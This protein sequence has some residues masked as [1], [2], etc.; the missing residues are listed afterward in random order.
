M[1]LEKK[2]DTGIIQVTI[3]L[4]FLIAGYYCTQVIQTHVMS[5]KI[6]KQALSDYGRSRYSN[7]YVKFGKVGMFSILKPYALYRQAMCANALS[8]ERSRIKSYNALL[9]RYPVHPL[10]LEAKYEV[11]QFLSNSNPKLA[12][13]YFK[14]IISSAG[15]NDYKVPARYF[16][17]KI[18]AKSCPYAK[19]SFNKAKISSIEEGF[20]NY[21]E[22]YPDGRLASAV[23]DSWI[24]YNPNN[25]SSHD[26]TL[27]A[28]GYYHSQQYDL[29]LK[30]LSKAEN[31][32]SWA[33]S[34]LNYMALN[35]YQRAQVY[36]K[37][38]LSR[39]SKFVTKD[40]YNLVIDK[41]IEKISNKYDTLSSLLEVAKD[42]KKDY[43]WYQK[44]LAA[45]NKDAG[46]CFKNLAKTYPESEYASDSLA[47]AF[48]IE[49]S[50]KDYKNAILTGQEFL[51]KYGNSDSI[52]L[53]LFWV[54][55][56]KQKYSSGSDYIT[57]FQNVIN[58]YPDTYYAYR[59]FWILNGIKT[60][61]VKT[62]M[63]YKPVEYPYKMPHKGSILK[64][65][66][67][68]E[69]YDMI[70]LISK[71]DFIKSWIEYQ[72]GNYPQSL[73]MAQKAMDKLKQKPIKTDLRWRLVY[74]QNYYKQ[75]SSSSIFY[76]NN[77]SLMTSIAKEESYFDSKAQ[78]DA[79][80]IGLMQLMPDTA[81]DVAAKYGFEKFNSYDLFNPELNVK[82]GNLYYA[83]L[84]KYLNNNDYYS[85]AAYNGGIGS[86]GRWIKEFKTD[87]MDEFIE[88][89]PYPETKTYVKKVL[90]S[91]WNYVRIYQR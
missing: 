59:A 32:D 2:K 7:A 54:G 90:R 91:Y 5:S 82:V 27:C 43:I 69:D 40:D 36:I 66:M 72:K 38:G 3:A 67:D 13:K 11:G 39:Y 35:D 15:D 89:I 55:K 22:K 80:A 87:D 34:A 37:T 83:N 88:Q 23:S 1:K 73:H 62:K 10:S 60:A 50:K 42:D 61:V 9:H 68:V 31:K 49:V 84:K 44:C 33:Y 19:F 71:D 51:S 18:D 29:S 79:G 53:V 46:V 30:T 6:Y 25:L 76:E 8:D 74:P 4:I 56:I 64:A 28:K 16:I 57:D 85:V 14:D 77:S 20:R 26:R 78:S 70:A 47:K 48:L 81:H 75:I 21:L 12:K 65:L 86:V 17:S 24:E 45:P 52:P 63:E 41:Y 58:N